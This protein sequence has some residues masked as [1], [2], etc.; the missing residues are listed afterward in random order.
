VPPSLLFNIPGF[1]PGNKTPRIEVGQGQL[2]LAAD[3]GFV[4]C[5]YRAGNRVIV[6]GISNEYLGSLKFSSWLLQIQFRSFGTRK[7]VLM[8]IVRV[9]RSV[10]MVLGS[11]SSVILL[12]LRLCVFLLSMDLCGFNSEWPFECNT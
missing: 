3:T 12:T 9:F 11:F 4:W 6:I 8:P 10:R 1:F 7:R 5:G 2:C